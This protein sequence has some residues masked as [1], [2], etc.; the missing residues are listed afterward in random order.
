[1]D[2]PFRRF[3][4]FMK[5]SCRRI[6][7]FFILSFLLPTPCF[8]VILNRYV[9]LR[10]GPNVPKRVCSLLQIPFE[11]VRFNKKTVKRKKA[12][13]S[14]ENVV[15]RWRSETIKS[16]LKQAGS[17]GCYHSYQRFWNI[18]KTNGSV[19]LLSGFFAE[20]T[21]KHAYLDDGNPGPNRTK[22]SN[23]K[24]KADFY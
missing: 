16:G 14:K 9:H 23:V 10:L 2:V 8:S 17:K 24:F 3:R 13:V 15:L 21:G 12:L 20:S 4:V 1:M 6:C 7:I 22:K 11:S 19:F 5:S 18:N